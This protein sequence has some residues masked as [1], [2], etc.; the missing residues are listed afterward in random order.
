[1]RARTAQSPPAR[2]RRGAGRAL[3][4]AL[5]IAVAATSPTARRPTPTDACS[6]DG[7]AELAWTGPLAVTPAVAETRGGAPTPDELAGEWTGTAVI[8][9]ARSPMRPVEQAMAPYLGV[10]RDVEATAS[11]ASAGATFT[12][13]GKGSAWSCPFALA[14]GTLTCATQVNGYRMTMTGALT[15]AGGALRVSGAWTASQPMITLR[16]SWSLT[17]PA[18]DVEIELLHPAGRSPK[19]FTSGWLF[20]ARC[21]RAKGTP[22]EADLSAEVEWGGTATFTPA[23]GTPVRPRFAT[24][25]TNKLTLTCG[26]AK[27]TFVIE[28]VRTTR[29]AHLGHRAH[30]PADA[31]GCLACPHSPTGPIVQGSPSVLVDGLPAA[32][33]GD[34]GMHAPC[35]GGNMFRIAGGNEEGVLIDGRP[36]ATLGALTLHCG[37]RGNIIEGSAGGNEPP[38]PP[39]P[40]G[41]GFFGVP[42]PQTAPGRAPTPPPRA[43]ASSTGEPPVSAGV[44]LDPPAI[45]DV[46]GGESP[47]LRAE[48]SAARIVRST[49][50]GAASPAAAIAIL[51]SSEITRQADGAIR[52]ARGAIVVTTL[53]PAKQL[54]VTD[55]GTIELGSQA[56]I[57]LVDEV[58]DVALLAGSATLR[59]RRGPEVRL[60]AGQSVRFS[61]TGATAP[62]ATMSPPDVSDAVRALVDPTKAAAPTAPAR[63]LRALLGDWRLWL[64]LGAGVAVGAALLAAVVIALAGRRRPT[65][66]GA[67][68]AR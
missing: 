6:L 45:E 42:S 17:K 15:R 68:P 13:G 28:T 3:D 8:T 67:P 52:L 31:H 60:A 33:S 5:L 7:R 23:R 59:P 61:A 37:G 1:M 62:P 34:Y 56:R 11:A 66:R 22:A 14:G 36:A 4:V 64:A 44:K 18:T 9:T 24:A 27:K 32:R 57:A 35:C 58:V 54:V 12:F 47:T 49:P 50:E 19:V 41:G 51:P 63:D 29:F 16:G 25:G 21:V 10:S 26:G 53:P 30:A 2:A 39:E 43:A 20:G 46:R 65:S 40:A 55:A 48:A 38:S